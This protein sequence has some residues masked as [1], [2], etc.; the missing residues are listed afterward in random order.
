[1]VQTNKGHTKPEPLVHIRRM[2]DTENS[3]NAMFTEE[4]GAEGLEWFFCSEEAFSN[5]NRIRRK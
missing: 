4:S 3:F 5:I 2:T 1:M